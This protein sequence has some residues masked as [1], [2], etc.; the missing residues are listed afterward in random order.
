M[1]HSRPVARESNIVRVAQQR[2]PI[3]PEV[4][5]GVV[6]ARLALVDGDQRAM[7][8]EAAEESSRR[9]AS[10]EDQHVTPGAR[11]VM[12]HLQA[13]WP[14]ADDQVVVYD[15]FHV[16]PRNWPDTRGMGPGAPGPSPKRARPAALLL[17]AIQSVD[18]REG[19]KQPIAFV[20]DAGTEEQAVRRPRV[21][22]IPE[23]EGPQAVDGH[24]RVVRV[25]QKADE[26]VSKAIER[27][28]PA[29]AEIADQDG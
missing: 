29:A 19:A 18:G 26:L 12:A 13:G 10:L 28:H 16:T 27:R 15:R 7:S 20:V 8:R 24:E 17:V 2:V 9:R 6:A 11:E 23:R 5:L 4:D 21:R 1:A 14:G 22:A 3:H 25:P